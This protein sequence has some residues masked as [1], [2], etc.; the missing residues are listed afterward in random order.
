MKQT[1]LIALAVPRALAA[2]A[3]VRVCG[4]KAWND[5]RKLLEGA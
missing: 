1:I 3:A 2:Y 4:W 5:N